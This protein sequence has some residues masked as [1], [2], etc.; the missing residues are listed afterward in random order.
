M[1]KLKS[2]LPNMILSLGVVSI[3][4]AALLAGMY[5]VTKEPIAEMEQQGRIEAIRRVAPEFDNNP[6]ADSVSVV[7]PA[8]VRCTVYPAYLRGKFNGAAVSTASSEGFGGTVQVMVGFDAAGAVKDYQ[9]L[10][11]AETPGLGSKMQQWFRD[12]KGARSIIGKSPAQVSF[13][14]VKDTERGGQ[15]DGITAATISSRAFLG[16]VR[17]GFEAYDAVR[18]MKEGGS[19]AA[20]AKGGDASSGAT[21]QAK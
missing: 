14:V 2:T 3:V 21:V 9:V 12:P 16:A 4:A 13:F 17:E 10:S 15:V 8:G 5:T 20:G 6:V 11:H 18:Q 1:K 19:P 7:T